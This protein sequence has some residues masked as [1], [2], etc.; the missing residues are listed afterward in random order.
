[1][2]TQYRTGELPVGDPVH[3]GAFEEP[4]NTHQKIHSRKPHNETN[5]SG[6][7][8]E[9]SKHRKY[10]VGDTVE[11]VPVGGPDSQTSRST[12]KIERILTSKTAAGDTGVRVN[13]TPDQPQYEVST[14]PRG[15]QFLRPSLEKHTAVTSTSSIPSNP[16]SKDGA[17]GAKFRDFL[18]EM[19]QT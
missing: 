6:E 7:F 16:G 14:K 15:F 13:A 8:Y 11:Y 17:F 10:E 5:Q 18:L 19:V 9:D 4:S 1:M 2:P 3:P 12:G